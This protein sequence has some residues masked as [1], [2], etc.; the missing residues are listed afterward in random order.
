MNIE[1]LAF[2][3][4]NIILGG[5]ET[6]IQRLATFAKTYCTDVFL[7]CNTIDKDMIK[8]FE[9]Q[10]VEVVILSSW[11]AKKIAKCVKN[12]NAIFFSLVDFLGVEIYMN[13]NRAKNI[14]YVIHPMALQLKR[15]RKIK[16]LHKLYKNMFWKVV[17]GYVKNGNIIF[18]DDMCIEWTEKYFEHRLN[19]DESD[20]YRIPMELCKDRIT[21]RRSPDGKIQILTIARADFPFKGYIKGLISDVA[22]L[23]HK[24]YNIYLTIISCGEHEDQVSQWVDSANKRGCEAIQL[25]GKVENNKLEDYYAKSDLYVGMG[26]TILEASRMGVISL[27]VKA[28]TYEFEVNGFFNEYPWMICANGNDLKKGVDYI[29][30]FMNKSENQIQQMQKET[31]DAFQQYYSMDSF[32]DRLLARQ[33]KHHNVAIGFGC[34]IYVDL[35]HIFNLFRKSRI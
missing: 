23:N 34:K 1:R 32:L 24:G 22:F 9:K 13:E 12:K 21:Q 25:I 5:A 26:T 20:I 35:W 18:M 28:Y 3:Y 8:A 17:Y 6:L 10:H 29:I 4:Q 16:I 15:L 30:E 7:Y 33:L 19:I 11:N 27:A 2:V 14:L 31:M